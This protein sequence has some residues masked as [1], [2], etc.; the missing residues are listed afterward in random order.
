MGSIPIIRKD[1]GYAEFEDLPICI[2]NNWSDIT[3]EF[4]ESE[5][6]RIINTNYNLEKLKISYWINKIN[7]IVS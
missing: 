4:L 6:N 3:L 5:K 7:N 1:I 2:V